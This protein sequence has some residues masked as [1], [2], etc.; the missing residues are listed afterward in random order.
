ME[1]YRVISRDF[2]P[3]RLNTRPVM[4]LID[5]LTIMRMG[6]PVRS[7]LGIRKDEEGSERPF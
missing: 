3:V 4:S 6:L 7:P 5:S 1:N 2:H